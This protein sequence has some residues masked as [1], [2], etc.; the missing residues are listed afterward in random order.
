MGAVQ[1]FFA[2]ALA[3]ILSALAIFS[4][5]RQLLTLRLLGSL[6]ETPEESQRERLQCWRRLTSSAFLLL[7]AVLLV[8]AQFWLEGPAEHLANLRDH[9]D[10]PLD[11]AQKNFLRLYSGVWI[12]ILLLLFVVVLLAAIDLWSIRR[13]GRLQQRKLRDDRRAMIARQL[14]RLREEKQEE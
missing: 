9:S 12:A 1:D 10:I 2:Y 13:F 14:R 8:V 5:R 6:A 7:I 4:C 11:S 3:L